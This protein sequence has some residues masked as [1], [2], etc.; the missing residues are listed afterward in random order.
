MRAGRLSTPA[1]IGLALRGARLWPRPL[2]TRRPAPRPPTPAPPQVR[3]SRRPPSTYRTAGQ[4]AKDLLS[5]LVNAVIVALRWTLALPGKIWALRLKSREEWAADWAK[6]KK[7][8]KHE[9]HHY[10]VGWGGGR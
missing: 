3:G 9:A 1:R 6:A 8:I 7:T 5:A 10:W 4:R 2:A